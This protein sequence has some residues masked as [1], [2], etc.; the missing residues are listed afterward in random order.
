MTDTRRA[1]EVVLTKTNI[2]IT[3][4]LYAEDETASELDVNSLSLRGAMREI[5]AYMIRTGYRSVGRWETLDEDTLT[6][7]GEVSRAFVAVNSH[8]RDGS[9]RSAE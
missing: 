4:T 5:T 3:A 9:F 6:G 1:T 8:Q 2:E 7:T